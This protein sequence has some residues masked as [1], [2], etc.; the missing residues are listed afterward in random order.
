MHGAPLAPDC[1]TDSGDV[2]ALDRRERRSVRGQAGTSGAPFAIDVAYEAVSP[3]SSSQ[4]PCGA[5]RARILG[6]IALL[7][8]CTPVAA[9]HPDWNVPIRAS[10]Y[11]PDWRSLPRSGCDKN[12]GS[13][14]QAG[15]L[16]WKLI[17][18]TIS[19]QIV[20]F[21]TP[22]VPGTGYKRPSHG[23]AFES[24]TLRSLLNQVGLDATRCQAPVV[25]VHTKLRDGLQGS[26]W[27]YARCALR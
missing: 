11:T 13:E 14:S 10:A 5:R 19:A 9:Q 26:A 21:K 24:D 15:R 7:A 18:S 22:E 20:E 3:M 4:A 17:P 8:V 12:C 6:A 27:F 1:S 16:S 2:E 23:L 25:K